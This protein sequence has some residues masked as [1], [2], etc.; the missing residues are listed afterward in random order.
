MP[1]G[2]AAAGILLNGEPVV[3]HKAGLDLQKILQIVRLKL[4]C[5]RIDEGGVADPAGGGDDQIRAAVALL[6]DHVGVA[7]DVIIGIVVHLLQRGT[8]ILPEAHVELAHEMAAQGAIPA[9]GCHIARL[10][11]IFIH[12][13]GV[14]IPAGDIKLVAHPHSGGVDILPGVG[15]DDDGLLI[16]HIGAVDPLEQ[17]AGH[18]TGG[19]GN[20]PDG[21]TVF[22]GD[23]HIFPT[24]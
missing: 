2:A 1:Q 24:D 19:M 4:L 9:D 17:L 5:V 18:R 23:L 6:S 13:E 20:H 7:I 15:E 16:L 10:V 22:V 11:R 8:Q 3:I 14:D 12:A 21:I